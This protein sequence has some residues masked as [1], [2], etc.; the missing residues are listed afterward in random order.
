M[1]KQTT[2]YCGRC[3]DKV[4]DHLLKL[5]LIG[6]DFSDNIEMYSLSIPQQAGSTNSRGRYGRNK[7]IL[8]VTS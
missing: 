6:E 3:V 2:I 4:I 1:G 5:T 8:T 7:L